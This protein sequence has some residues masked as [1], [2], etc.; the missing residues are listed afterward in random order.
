MRAFPSSGSPWPIRL[1]DRTTAMPFLRLSGRQA[2]GSSSESSG[3]PEAGV[4]PWPT[5]IFTE[6][7]L[8]L[9]FSETAER[10]LLAAILLRFW[11]AISLSTNT[12]TVSP[13]LQDSNA[14]LVSMTGLGHCFP[15]SSN[16]I[17]RIL[18]KHVSDSSYSRKCALKLSS[19]VS[20]YSRFENVCK[21]FCPFAGP[22]FIFSIRKQ[23]A[24]FFIYTDAEPLFYNQI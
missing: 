3:A 24:I 15:R 9:I 22:A 16:F 20:N 5:G 10:P 12:S 2:A 19:H 4:T 21:R 8:S 1:E 13:G 17:V 11:T 18:L 14:F 7:S 6:N 23:P